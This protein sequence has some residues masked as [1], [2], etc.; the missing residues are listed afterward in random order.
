MLLAFLINSQ[1]SE[2]RK[3][4][5]CKIKSIQH[6]EKQFKLIIALKIAYE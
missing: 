1:G 5:N 6:Y 3:L 2:A 4:G